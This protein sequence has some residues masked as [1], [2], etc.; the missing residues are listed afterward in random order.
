MSKFLKE[1][2]FVAVI[3]VF[4]IGISI[5]FAWDQNKGKLPGKTTG[6]KDVVFS[7]D[8]TDFT[9]DELYDELAKSYEKSEY[10]SMFQQTVLNESV[11]STDDFITELK[12]QYN[13]VVSYYSSN[14][15]Y[16]ENYLNQIARYYYGYDTFY[17]YMLYSRKAEELYKEYIGKHLDELYTAELAEKLNPRTVSYVVISMSDPKNPTAEESELL[18]SAQ[19]AWNSSEYTAENFGQFAAKYSQDSGA[20]KEGKFGYIDSDTT[21]VD[22]VFKETALSLKEGEVSEWVFSEKFGYFL[23]KCDSVKVSDFLEESNFINTILSSKDN[24]N[25][26]IMWDK[27]NELGLTINDKNAEQYIKDTLKLESEAD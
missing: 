5:Y 3:L 26:Q 10:V 19:D 7:V 14:Y 4:F 8:N 1:N 15:G 9:A 2:W 18:K 12:N 27:A 6:G 16:D 20:S 11:K 21:G 13:N 17:D 22:S 24:L 23:I 25:N